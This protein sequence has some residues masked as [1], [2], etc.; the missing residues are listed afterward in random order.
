M[1]F[2][3]ASIGAE[4]KRGPLH[5]SSQRSQPAQPAAAITPPVGAMPAQAPQFDVNPEGLTFSA[6]LAEMASQRPGG[7]APS[8]IPA[9]AITPLPMGAMPAQTPQFGSAGATQQTASAP[10]PTS[11]TTTTATA[12]VP[13]PTPPPPGGVLPAA[14][15]EGHTHDK[16]LLTRSRLLQRPAFQGEAVQIPEVRTLVGKVEAYE[17]TV[18]EFTIPVSGGEAF[19][20]DMGRVNARV[21]SAH[22]QLID[23]MAQASGTLRQAAV[24]A[25]RTRLPKIF[26]RPNPTVI[27]LNNL[28]DDVA[29][30]AVILQSQ[31]IYL[32]K[33]YDD[34]V[35]AAQTN[36][37]SLRQYFGKSYAE[38]IRNMGMYHFD[39]SR[40]TAS[41]LG[42]G[43]INTVYRDE[44]EG[45]GR[46]FKRGKTYETLRDNGE[47]NTGFNVLLDR[48]GAV[49]E[50]LNY[51][52]SQST[53]IGEAVKDAN[54][55]QRDVAY[56]RLN[57]LFGFDIAVNTQLA[58]SEE[59]ESSS[60]MDMVQG[61][62]GG[63]FGEFVYYSSLDAVDTP[64]PQAAEEWAGQEY[65]GRLAQVD[66]DL[67][68]QER[69][70]Q[71][72]EAARASGYKTESDY[73]EDMQQIDKKV[74]ELQS[75]KAKLQKMKGLKTLDLADPKVAL[76]LLKM[77][78]LDLVAGHVDRH[79]G[80]F[81][82]SQNPGGETKLTAIDN[83][84]SFG[85]NTDIGRGGHMGFGEI[86]PVLEEAF[87]FVPQEILD[88]TMGVS[89]EDL[90]QALTGLLSGP[91]ITAAA[92]R[93]RKV[94]ELFRQ[95]QEAHRVE[96]VTA[97]NVGQLL[98]RSSEGS[99]HGRLFGFSMNRDSKFKEAHTPKP[100]APKPLPPTPGSRPP[101]RSLPPTPGSRPPS[102]PLPTPQG[103]RPLPS[104]PTPRP[105]PTPP[106]TRQ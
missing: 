42:A 34:M 58:K 89:E 103:R 97:G 59:G 6:A 41:A 12:P 3:R 20:R 98:G 4:K 9:P 54:T 63:E 71:N 15:F 31:K 85:T 48:L 11:A 50:E 57:K 78:V 2:Q 17:Q 69:A 91:Q 76:Q 79:E 30:L 95:L 37:A 38:V 47:T 86:R 60:L 10:T 14:S 73:R 35:T 84:T 44:Y 22:E 16:E 82:I 80:N 46:V 94:Q 66:I 90:R 62:S 65:R 29:N 102:R 18:G 43:A 96:D 53:R 87:P 101:S 74:R 93:L 92:E 81:M 8:Q 99:Y 23:T 49:A 33:I 105:L 55:A 75:R 88:K 7:G 77:S 19:V 28:A 56:S 13:I 26:N 83:D 27:R 67:A 64:W 104:T 68:A 39:S 36:P 40:G 100:P 24:E 1:P 32:N 61:S 70:R 25:A 21:M 5:M 52:G 106:G 45:Q 72:S 51:G